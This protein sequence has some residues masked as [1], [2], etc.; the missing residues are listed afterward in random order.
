MY[1]R[2][3][4]APTECLVYSLHMRIHQQIMLPTQT[5]PHNM[6]LKAVFSYD[7]FLN[8]LELRYS[9]P[10][11]TKDIHTLTLHRVLQ[12]PSMRKH[13][14]YHRFT[15]STTA[16]HLKTR[17]TFIQLPVYSSQDNSAPEGNLKRATFQQAAA[18]VHHH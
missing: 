18:T 17:Y 4:I 12:I 13:L 14:Y 6:K 16:T 5:L 11:L 8:I 7:Y 2:Y 15:L 9:I 1:W 3:N 10:Y